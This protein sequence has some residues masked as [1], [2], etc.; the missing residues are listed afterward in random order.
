MDDNQ[1]A[2][3]GV[4]PGES[5]RAAAEPVGPADRK[6]PAQ[7]MAET[8]ARLLDAVLDTLA[9]CGYAA[10]STNEVAR[11]SG[12][13]RGAQLHH[14]GTKDQMIV[15]AVEHLSARTNAADIAAALERLPEGQD[16]LR[17]VLEIMSQL[18]LGALP[19]AYVELWVA[20]RTH[21]ELV[22]ALRDSDVVA[23]DAVRSLFGDDILGRAGPEFD[24]LLDLVLYALRGM[25]LDA[26]LASDDERRARVELIL[27]MAKYL[28]QALQA[29]SR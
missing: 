5:E 15:A 24:D 8:R 14:F 6:S 20:S 25:A 11:R 3:P 4:T 16:R 12:L 10:T 28:E 21:S 22:D 26:H 29:P 9:E 19:A 23:R 13:T 2:E 17:T 27:G 18:S 7:R 1:E